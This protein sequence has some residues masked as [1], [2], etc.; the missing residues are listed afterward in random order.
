MAIYAI[1]LFTGREW[2]CKMGRIGIDGCRRRQ[3]ARATVV[4][5]QQGA[6]PRKQSPASDAEGENRAP[7]DNVERIQKRLDK[8]IAVVLNSIKSGYRPQ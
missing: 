5:I 7:C 4:V 8:L 1:S 2:G 6:G 3:A